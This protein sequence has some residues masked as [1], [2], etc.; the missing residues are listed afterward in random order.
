MLTIKVGGEEHFDEETQT[1]STIGEVRFDVEHSLVSLSKWESRFGK[2]F[3]GPAEKSAEEIMCY[4]EAMIVDPKVDPNLIYAC[5]QEEIDKIQRYIDSPSSATTFGEMPDRNGPRET[6]TS[7]LIYYWMIAYNIPFECQHWHL[8]RL[9]ALIKI[10]NIKNSPAKK[11]SRS[12]IA[13]R[14][15]ELNERRRAELG[16]KG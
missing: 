10:C 4:L 16:T 2:P 13:Q 3:L 12:Q 14:N 7:E 6:I 9:F 8:N 1:F 11:M 5:D 15:R